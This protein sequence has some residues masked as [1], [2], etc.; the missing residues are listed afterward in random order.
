[1][2]VI[3][4]ELFLQERQINMKVKFIK[5]KL[6][7][8]WDNLH[9]MSDPEIDYSDIPLLDKEIFQKGELRMPKSKPLISIGL[10]SNIKF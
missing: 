7:T 5:K 9:S 4:S 8:D 1:M 10:D 3:S 6:K 2:M